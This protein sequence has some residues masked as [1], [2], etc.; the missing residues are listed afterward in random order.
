MACPAVP[1]H[2]GAMLRIVGMMSGTSLDGI[3]AALIDP[4]A[5]PANLA[6]KSAGDLLQ[7][8]ASLATELEQAESDWLEEHWAEGMG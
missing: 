8:R 3:D 5:A 1:Y 7:R 4:G 2:N 6:S